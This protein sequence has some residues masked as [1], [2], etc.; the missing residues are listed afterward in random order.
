MG[1]WSSVQ[2]SK[3]IQNMQDLHDYNSVNSFLHKLNL[4][5]VSAFQHS[6]RHCINLNTQLKRRKASIVSSSISKMLSRFTQAK[7]Q[8]R[9]RQQQRSSKFQTTKSTFTSQRNNTCVD[10]YQL[11]N[12]SL[13]DG[14]INDADHT[15]SAQR[16]HR[17]FPQSSNSFHV[18]MISNIN[19][20]SADVQRY[21]ATNIDHNNED[22]R[23]ALCLL[24]MIRDRNVDLP[25][26]FSSLQGSHETRKMPSQSSYQAFT[27]SFSS[28][29][30]SIPASAE[31]SQMA[32]LKQKKG[33]TKSRSSQVPCKSP[34]TEISAF[35]GSVSLYTPGDVDTLSPV[36]C[37]IR[38]A[39]IEAFVLT[40]EQAADKKFWNGRNF[41]GKPV[42]KMWT[43]TCIDVLA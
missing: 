15:P 3:G 33:F 38:K 35:Y 18:A 10:N 11:G 40:E 12:H 24:S 22:A 29:N 39:G 6:S 17:S 16:D 14:A 9:A 21:Q 36:H 31:S 26:L 34:T 42:T 1:G 4:I 37:F 28:S 27:R 25:C 13:E 2:G 43:L 23:A 32:L 30:T 5:I 19:H 8:H 7:R 20:N 41:N